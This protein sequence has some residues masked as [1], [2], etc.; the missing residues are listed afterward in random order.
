MV[1]LHGGN[2]KQGFGGG[3]LYNGTYLG[4]AQ[5]E[6]IVV[7]NYRLGALGFLASPED[8]VDGNYG[9]LDQVALLQWVQSNIQAFGGNPNHVTLVGQSAGAGSIA[10]HLISPLSK[11]LFHAAVL[12]SNPYA[13]P[14][15]NA[16]SMPAIVKALLKHA[17]CANVDCLRTLPADQMIQAQV[18]TEVD[19]N[20]AGDSL[21]HAF[22][23]W[24]PYVDG[25]VVPDQPLLA[26]QKG[27]FNAVP[28]M[29]GTVFDE[30]VPFVYGAFSKPVDSF[31]YQIVASLIFGSDRATR[32]VQ[33]YPPPASG[34][35]R[36]TLVTVGS[37]FIFHCAVRNATRALASRAPTFL[38]MYDHVMS[39]GEAGWGPQFPEC[40]NR[41]CH[42]AEL[43][44][45]WNSA[46]WM[47]PYTP[48]EIELARNMG[49]YWGQFIRSYTPSQNNAN[50]PTTHP[51]E[52]LA[53]LV[54]LSAK[55]SGLPTW[56][57]YSQN[58]EKLLYISASTD[59]GIQV[60]D[61]WYSAQCDFWDSIGY[62]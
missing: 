1:Y 45:L 8:G 55:K 50:E 25:K 4:G 47:F 57:Q 2:Y 37:E 22:L 24:T 7:G 62:F 15:R 14:F 60:I 48:A 49:D 12:H 36:E 43:A 13:I 39:F 53:Q 33:K 11:G 10:T 51:F 46:Q 31:S 19:L 29:I 3:P 21:L 44:F 38:Y 17:N 5:D 20:A 35:A 34:D 26:L 52:R 23:P 18:A 16:N 27:N 58:N 54:G 32:V 9:F 40:W 59:S 30:S 41:C 42:A 61:K 56:P 28:T 6:I